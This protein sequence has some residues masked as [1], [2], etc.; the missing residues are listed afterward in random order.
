MSCCAPA[1]PALC[2]ADD[3]L[4]TL[5]IAPGGTELVQEGV[6]LDELTPQRPH[7]AGRTGP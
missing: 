2:T 1:A 5:H 4:D 3:V 7:R 6:M